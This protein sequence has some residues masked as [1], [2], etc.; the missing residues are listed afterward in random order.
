MDGSCYAP[1]AQWA[2]AHFAHAALPDK[3]LDRRL[4]K[5][6]T[7]MAEKPGHSLPQQCQN[8]AD[9]RAAYGLLNHPKVSPEDLQ[10]PHRRLTL[11]NCRQHPVVLAVQ[12]DSDL[13]F[14]DHPKVR[15]LGSLGDGRGRGIMQH[16][17]LAV[18]PDGSVLG[19][20]DQRFFNRV[21]TPEGETRRQRQSRWCESDVWSDAIGAMTALRNQEGGTPLRL[22]HVTDRGGDAWQTVQA[23]LRAGDGFLIRLRH[24]RMQTDGHRLWEAMAQRPAAGRYW[25]HIPKQRDQQGHWRMER[26][27]LVTLRYGPVTLRRP[28]NDPRCRDD[29]PVSAWAVYVCEENPPVGKHIEPVDW[30]L[31]CSEPV[32][33]LEGALRMVGWYCRRWTI[34]EFH[35]VEKEGCGI[36]QSQLDTA[37]DLRRLAA[38]QSVQSVRLLQLR[39]LADFGPE[40]PARLQ[41]LEE[42]AAVKGAGSKPEEAG[43]KSEEAGAKSDVAPKPQAASPAEKSPAAPQGR[44]SRA[45]DPAALQAVLPAL[46]ILVVSRLAQVPESQLTPRQFWL[47]IAQRGGYLGRKCDRRPGWKVMWRGWCEVLRIIE[48]AELIN[49]PPATKLP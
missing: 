35:R 44:A 11:Q 16:T 36:E 46:W 19:L 29:A 25:L 48:G 15:G 43:A 22:I 27:A 12:D 4:V 47:T 49:G 40:P 34:E 24:D 18:L 3:R 31:L 10:Q 9:L 38:I 17:T 33:D 45:D 28:V 32:E 26:W 8:R 2:E 37:A 41:P 21:E 5:L 1:A 13:D 14:T 6:T 23:A 30:M 7:A 42:P 20:L 39:D